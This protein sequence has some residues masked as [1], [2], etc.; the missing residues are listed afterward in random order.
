V[1]SRL[2]GAAR[3]LAVQTI[4]CPILTQCLGADGYRLACY[5]VAVGPG[6]PHHGHWIP[7]PWVGHLAEAPLLFVSSNPAG[8]GEPSSDPEDPSSASSDDV[9]LACQDGAFDEGQLPGIAEGEYLVDCHGTRG[10]WVRYWRWAKTCATDV[11]PKMPVPGRDYALTE[12]VHCGSPNEQGVWSALRTCTTR[13]LQPVLAASPADVVVV[14]G[15]VAKFA[16]GEHLGPDAPSHLQGP[17]EVAGKER[18]LVFVPH[19]SSFGGNKPLSDHLS[20]AE[21][22]QVREALAG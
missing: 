7:E 2:D 15:A 16:F 20:P 3:E 5:D 18:L 19:P 22:A 14:V 11:F 8:G 12:V 21:L 6:S 9:L 13:Y 17:V 10:Q 1:A 4:R